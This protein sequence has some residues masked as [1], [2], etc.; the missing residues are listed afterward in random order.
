M[1]RLQFVSTPQTCLPKSQTCLHFSIVLNSETL[2][3]CKSFLFV[4]T[5]LDFCKKCVTVEQQFKEKKT[6]VTADCTTLG[7]NVTF[8]SRFVC[9]DG[10]VQ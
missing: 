10:T 5:G 6:R 4:K 1:I 2:A 7:E 8:A 3:F 9:F